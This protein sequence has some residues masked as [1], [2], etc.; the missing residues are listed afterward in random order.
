MGAAI[1]AAA[2]Q[3]GNGAINLSVRPPGAANININNNN[4]I[5]STSGYTSGGNG[6]VTGL[7]DGDSVSGYEMTGQKRG[8]GYSS[9][10][11]NN[12]NGETSSARKRRKQM[13]VP[14]SNKDEKYWARRLKNNEAAKRSRDMRIKREKDVFEE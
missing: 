10:A 5:N 1:Q 14:D 3:A 9:S 12:Q 2:S 11:S 4:N 7:S 6:S 8:G 13:H